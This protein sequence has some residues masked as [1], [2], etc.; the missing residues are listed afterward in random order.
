MTDRELIAWIDRERVGRL[1]EENDQWSFEYHEDWLARPGAF[2]LSPHLP[3]QAGRQTDGASRRQVRWFFDNL[4]PEE[5][6]RTLLASDARVDVADAFGLLT[7]YGSESAGSVTLL[8]PGQEET[9]HLGSRPLE[10]A[11][12]SER[13]RNLPRIALNRESP[14]RM[15]LAGAQ[16]KLAVVFDGE[17][18]SE[19]IGSTP[20]THILKPDHPHPD[21]P[22]SVVNEWFTMRLAGRLG[23]TVPDVWRRYVPE[24]VYLIRRF[25]RI[26]EQETWKRRHVIDACQ[27]LGLDRTYK[28][29]QGSIERLAELAAACRSPAV[30][31]TR[32]YS[33][34][35]FNL[36][37]GNN[38]AH[39]KNLSFTVGEDG[40]QLA[41]HYDMLSTAVYGTR[42]FDKE[43]WPDATELSWP[44]LGRVR[45]A[46]I[47]RPL[48]LETGRAMGLVTSTA[49]RLLTH[50]TDRVLEHAESLLKEV[51]E[52]N[53]ALSQDRP[54]LGTALAGEVRCLRAVIRVVIRDV[55][56]KLSE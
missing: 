23:L 5:E 35:V 53:R 26:H 47:D 31:R 30:A 56:A 45:Y 48:V 17:T 43:H 39:L 9:G 18:L 21:Y 41:P 33:W 6:Q 2:A 27:L 29:N 19:P 37:T 28:Y 42:A 15:S 14:K 11:T 24:P 3:L 13:I 50:Q 34:L 25:D 55:A 4:L 7:Y 40:I 16:H 1:V 32:L 36:L 51:E 44:V 8:P 38:D 52:E 22:H 20:S 12:L 10:D 54:E 46:G 49:E